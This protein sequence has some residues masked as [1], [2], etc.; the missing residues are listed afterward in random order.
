MNVRGVPVAEATAK[1][2]M[3]VRA[4]LVRRLGG[5]NEA[6]VWTRIDFRLQMVTP[7]FVDDE[8][9]PWWPASLD[10]IA[11]ETGLSRDQAHRAVRAL[12]ESGALVSFEHRL[13]GNYDRTKSYRTVVE[14]RDVDVADSRYETSR[15][16]NQDVAES[17]HVPISQESKKK[18]EGG[19]APRSRGSR[20]PDPFMLTKAMR[21]WAAEKVPGFDVDAETEQFVDYWRGRSGAGGVKADWAAT[22]RNWMRR[23]AERRGVR[24]DAPLVEEFAPGD[25]WMAMSR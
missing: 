3:M 12:L 21:E 24:A 15:I 4:A 16:R 22:W 2:F 13:N 23:A 17:R 9:V 14:G 10:T 6:L 11:D 19:S 25:E 1:D 5:A 7:P 8:G 20:I 18:E